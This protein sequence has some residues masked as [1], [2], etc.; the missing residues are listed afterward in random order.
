MLKKNYFLLKDTIFTILLL[1]FIKENYYNNKHILRI[2]REYL[3][4]KAKSIELNDHDFNEVSTTTF[5]NFKKLETLCFNNCKVRKLFDDKTNLQNL[6]CLSLRDCK[7]DDTQFSSL[8]NIQKIILSCNYMRRITQDLFLGLKNLKHLNLSMNQISVIENGTFQDCI[9]LVDLDLSINNISRISV[10]I[11]RGLSNL[12]MLNLNKNETPEIEQYAFSHLSSL[13]FLSIDKSDFDS[14][15]S[16]TF[17]G[18]CNLEELNIRMGRFR[19]IRENAFL[20]CR[21]LKVLKII[22]NQLL[23][24]ENG[25]NELN[26]LELF[27]ASYVCVQIDH[28]NNLPNLKRFKCGSLGKFDDVL[29]ESLIASKIEVIDLG[30]TSLSVSQC[31][32]LIN[33]MSCLKEFIIHQLK[34][35]PN[36]IN[37]QQHSKKLIIKYKTSKSLS[38]YHVN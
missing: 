18:L 15:T 33:N 5:N 11:F 27:D 29:L 25:F 3:Y 31:A 12:E 21:N 19:R 1:I 20:G 7:F 13:K 23:I 6:Q 17:K 32:N 35:E 24:D 36:D 8:I 10:D 28:F 30:K 38:L 22:T 37:N 4:E 16:E 9:N 34:L 26:S 14:V 2:N